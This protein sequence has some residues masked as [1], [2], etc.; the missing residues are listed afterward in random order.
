[1]TAIGQCISVPFGGFGYSRLC[2][3]CR[4]TGEHRRK[5]YFVTILDCHN[6]HDHR[7]AAMKQFFFDQL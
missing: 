5:G 6:F 3:L 2:H 7:S 1:M 4:N